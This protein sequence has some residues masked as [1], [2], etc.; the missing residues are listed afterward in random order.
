MA[1]KQKNKRKNKSPKLGR[2]QQTQ[3][4]EQ[5]ML[6]QTL[7]KFKPYINAE[8]N[9]AAQDIAN[10]QKNLLESLYVRVRTLE[11]LVIEKFKDISKDVLAARIATIEDEARN[12]DEVNIVKKGDR[13]RIS[14]STKAKDK[15]KYEGTSKL[16]IDQVGTGRTVGMELENALL[17]MKTS[18]VKELEFGKDKTMV[19]KL[20]VN[21]ISRNLKAEAEQKAKI[22]A[23]A[24]AAIAE[25]K[26]AITQED[27]ENHAAKVVNTPGSVREEPKSL[28][29]EESNANSN[30]G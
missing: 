23:E 25:S 9:A 20:T 10:Q 13:V 21:R 30:E 24:K 28:N 2:K 27:I 11:E 26:G 12:L 16:L 4:F 15:D 14:I 17:N 3:S 18:E 19:A 8:I 1:K 7:N 5:H 22:E 29:K 6:T